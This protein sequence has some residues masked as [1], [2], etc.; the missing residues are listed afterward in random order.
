MNQAVADIIKEH[1]ENLDFVD[2]IAGLVSTVYMDV[3]DKDNNLV[4]KAFPIAC[5]VTAED[6][7][8]GAYNDLMPNSQYDTVIYFEDGGV[9]FNKS[10]S[11]WKYYTS[12]L[13]L[14]CWINVAK[15]LSDTCK[16]GTKCTRS[17]HI[18]TEII[19]A[20]PTFPEDHTP[21]HRFYSEVIGQEIRDN[22]IFGKYTFD[23]KHVQY[24]MYPYDYFALTIRTDFA[25]CMDSDVV[26]DVCGDVITQMTPVALT[27]EDVGCDSFKAVW[28]EETEATGYFLDVSTVSN[29]AS[30]VAGYNNLNVGN[31][32]EYTITGLVPDTYYYRVRCYDDTDTS[33]NSNIITVRVL[34]CDWFLPSMLEMDQMNTNLYMAGIGGLSANKYW[35]SSQAPPGSTDRARYYLFGTA[36]NTDLKTNTYYVRAVRIFIAGAGTYALGDNGPAGGWIFYIDGAGT[37]YYECSSSDQSISKAWSNI[38][39]DCP[40]TDVAIGTGQ[41]NTNLIIAQAGHTDSAAKLCNDLII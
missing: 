34:A 35:S 14:V 6:C 2:K 16:T 32:F 3:S 21:F 12:T 29:F 20:L 7:K 31:V 15:I 26:P 5:C 22:S 18:I 11:N 27:A 13:K 9:T 8:E 37:T 10:E 30:F 23:E 40:G 19:R 1:I 36:Q 24:L 28:N 33:A 41:T 39:N 38:T 17:A 4:Q 25:I